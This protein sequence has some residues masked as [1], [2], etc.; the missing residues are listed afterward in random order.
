MKISLKV[1]AAALAMAL[2]AMM[3][4]G[5]PALA[6][7]SKPDVLAKA[8][9]TFL[10]SARGQSNDGIFDD[11]GETC[12]YCPP[13]SENCGCFLSD[14]SNGGTGY[15]QFNNGAQT[16]LT[17]TIEIDYIND[18]SSQIPTTNDSAVC[19][20]AAGVGTGFQTG[21]RQ[22]N[23]FDFE[24]TGQI[25]NT[26]NGYTTFTGS[27]IMDEGSGNYANATGSGSLIIGAYGNVDNEAG[28]MNQVQ[29]T[30]NLGQ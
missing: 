4:N 24:T 12:A 5:Q 22:V 30:G 13:D 28:F 10:I 23:S 26:T 11:T 17:W 8:P 7:S 9:P 25:C 15:F 20:P 29:F 14:A 19:I 27:Y 16:P 21:G 18:G 2:A 3:S 6:K 1:V